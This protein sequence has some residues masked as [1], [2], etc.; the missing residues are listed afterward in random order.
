[1][2][3]PSGAGY[4]ARQGTSPSVRMLLAASGWLAVLAT[5]LLSGDSV[6]RLIVVGAFLALAPGAALRLPL[7]EVLAGQRQSPEQSTGSGTAEAWL[8]SLLLS[9]SALVL[10]SVGLMLTG[11]FTPLT[12]LV[13]LSAITMAAALLPTLRPRQGPA[14]G[15]ERSGS[16]VKRSAADGDPGAPAG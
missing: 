4:L 11:S 15:A 16:E 3:S 14:S 12:T 7:R 1:M 9:L 10:V 13:V 2:S 5:E 6:P 8:A